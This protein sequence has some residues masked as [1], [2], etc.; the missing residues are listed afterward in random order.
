MG[1]HRDAWNAIGFAPQRWIGDLGIS[2]PP[3]VWHSPRA[4]TPFKL[5]G[6]RANQKEPAA[7]SLEADVPA[8]HAVLL[9]YRASK[10][11]RFE[12]VGASANGVAVEPRYVEATSFLYTSPTNATETVHWQFDVRADP[13]YVDLLSFGSASQPQSSE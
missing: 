1:L 3:R 10:F 12:L 2:A 9:S 5:G 6:F 7:L 11:G 13:D 4:I 8:N